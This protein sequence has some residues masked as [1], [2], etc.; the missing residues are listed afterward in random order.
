MQLNLFEGTCYLTPLLGAWLADSLWGRYKTIIVFSA[1]Y[2]VVSCPRCAML[3]AAAP[4]IAW[5]AAGAARRRPSLRIQLLAWP[6]VGG[7]PCCVLS[8]R[9]Q[10]APR[11]AWA[12]AAVLAPCCVRRK[13]QR[14]PASL[15]PV[16][17]GACSD[18]GYCGCRMRGGNVLVAVCAA[19][20][21]RTP[22]HPRP[23]RPPHPT[24]N[25][26]RPPLQGMVMLA[27]SAW[28]PG[29]TPSP[30]EYASPLQNAALYT[31]LYVIALG[32]GGIKPNVSAFG[33]DQFDEADPKARAQGARAV[34]QVPLRS[35]RQA[36]S[37]N[38][39]GDWG[40]PCR[41]DNGRRAVRAVARR[42]QLAFADSRPVQQAA[43]AP[44]SRHS[45]HPILCEITRE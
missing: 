44:T 15:Q 27:L 13:H 25:P 36:C 9:A 6:A 28:L 2:F 31:S 8:I 1:I 32:T 10:L 40:T 5:R 42:R 38:K 35:D 17:S 39:T 14:P 45:T 20:S 12:S 18:A 34:A 41:C 22:H 43:P 23:P 26:P 30:D 7:A 19:P 37:S 4:Q 21:C 11:R 29:L 24:P 33:A 16:P 3:C